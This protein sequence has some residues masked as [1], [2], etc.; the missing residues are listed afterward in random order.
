MVFGNPV[1]D[2]WYD[3]PVYDGADQVRDPDATSP[4]LSVGWREAF[5]PLPNRT[6][7]LADCLGQI[8]AS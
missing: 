8:Q 6:T 3:G 7:F 4:Y 5:A 2:A 1:S